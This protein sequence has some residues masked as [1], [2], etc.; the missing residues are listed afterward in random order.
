MTRAQLSESPIKGM[1][2]YGSHNQPAGTWSDDTSMVLCTLQSILEE[3]FNP[4]D[5]MHKFS[6]WKTEG[7]MSPHGEVFDIGHTVSEAID[8]YLAGEP[9]N[10]WGGKKDWQN[11]N[12]SLM[13]MLPVSLFFHR[14]TTGTIVEKS[15]TASGLTHDHKLAKFCCAWYS[16]IVKAIIDEYNFVDAC[17]EAAMQMKPYLKSEDEQRFQGL[18]TL[19]FM[20]CKEV[21]I[22][23]DSYA[24]H[25]LEAALFSVASTRTFEEAVLTAVNLGDD[26][27]TVGALAGGLAGLIYGISAIRKDWVEH[28]AQEPMLQE[29]FHT[30]TVRVLRDIKA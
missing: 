27:D 29:L 9:R 20:D 15:F 25:T 18:L 19:R 21:D 13:R 4:L 14:E 5:I 17:K 23:S 22:H 8:R 3:G 12:G 6:L 7:Y 24:V 30:F 26:T 1:T 16:L 2:G 11:G 28:L 10:N